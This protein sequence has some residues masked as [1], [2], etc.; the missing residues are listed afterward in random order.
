MVG[1]AV[2]EVE[3]VVVC[4]GEQGLKPVG[5]VLE[6]VV[7][8]PA[9]ADALTFLVVVVVG[10][11]VWVGVLEQAQLHWQRIEGCAGTF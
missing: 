11:V 8:V 3:E 6:V 7:L 5:V 4:E 2:V 9:T 1:F 10:V